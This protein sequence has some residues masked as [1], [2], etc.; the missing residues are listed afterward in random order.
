MA[1]FILLTWIGSKPV[2]EPFEWYIIIW[3]LTPKLT[4]QIMQQFYK[5]NF[6]SPKMIER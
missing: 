5:S 6:T 4:L 1:N 2:E 3:W